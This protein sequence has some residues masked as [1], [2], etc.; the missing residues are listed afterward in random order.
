M[1]KNE[2]QKAES[3]LMT[4]AALVQ[5]D[6][7]MDVA[8]LKELL[9][10][11]ERWEA[12][13][14]KK[15]YVVAMS[16]FKANPPEILKDK[17]VSYQTSKGVT[18]YKHATLSNVT[19][20]INKALS[21]HGLTASWITSQDNGSVKVTCRITH[22]EGHSEETALSAPPDSTGSKNAI[23]SIGS[24]VTYLQRYTLLAL[25]GLATYD[26]DDDGKGAG[27]EPKEKPELPKPNEKEQIALDAIYKNLEASLPEDR[28]LLKEKIPGIFYGQARYPE[29]IAKVGVAASWL[30]SLGQMDSWTKD[31][32]S[33]DTEHAG[34]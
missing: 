1:E 11:Q 6:G 23:Q 27:N 29:D 19:T 5:A 3:P 25:T 31:K 4:A 9:D 20:C 13:Q 28:V 10:V 21:M 2:I 22:I 17:T 32:E 26:Q 18:D 8:K 24:T 30:I 14:A 16:E 34:V 15:S 7:N 33:K 12:I